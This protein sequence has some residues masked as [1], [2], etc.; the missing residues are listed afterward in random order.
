MKIFCKTNPDFYF[1]E[2]DEVP[3]IEYSYPS[4]FFN[5]NKFFIHSGDADKKRFFII[6]HKE[7]KISGTINLSIQNDIAYSP[8][9]APFGS[10]EFDEGLAPE[11]IFEFWAFLELWC[12]EHQ[13]KFLYIKTY[14]FIYQPENSALLMNTMLCFGYKIQNAE[15][16]QHILVNENPFLDRVS[17]SEKKRINKCIRNNLR[18]AL[19]GV[20]NLEVSYKLIKESRD[21]KN[22]PT[23]MSFNELK[24]VF[25]KFPENYY[26]FTVLDKENI[27]ALSVSILINNKI[28]YNFYHAHDESYNQLSPITFVVKGIYE[29]CQE[30]KIEVLD[31]GISTA[32]NILNKGLF[33]FKRNLG[34]KTS[35]KFSFFKDLHQEV[36]AV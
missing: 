14:P 9:K 31:L 8:L 6:N 27:V 34:A 29:Y 11:I 1:F 17:Y 25:L 5:C 20:E 28:L 22:Y 13:V 24:S 23:S 36:S 30:Q 7:N 12:K 4:F 35:L 26:L 2:S 21:R 33:R 19:S 16:N 3:Q 10:L 32:E 15:L 18:F